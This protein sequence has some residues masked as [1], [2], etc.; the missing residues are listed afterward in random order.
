[1]LI[2]VKEEKGSGSSSKVRFSPAVAEAKEKEELRKTIRRLEERLRDGE[3]KESKLASIG[4][5]RKFSSL[6]TYL[7][8]YHKFNYIPIMGAGR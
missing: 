5:V 1:M 7:S 6:A 4:D 2:K 8:N 3:S